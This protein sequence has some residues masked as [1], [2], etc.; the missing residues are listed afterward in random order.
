MAQWVKVFATKDDDVPEFNLEMAEWTE[1]P[2]MSHAQQVSKQ[3]HKEITT[4]P[5]S[6]I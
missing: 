5:L 2:S 1:R 6:K 3:I 4:L